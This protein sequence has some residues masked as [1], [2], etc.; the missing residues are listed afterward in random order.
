M[1]GLEGDADTN[2]DKKI[3]AESNGKSETLTGASAPVL[4]FHRLQHTTHRHPLNWFDGTYLVSLWSQFWM[5]N[6]VI[7]GLVVCARGVVRQMMTS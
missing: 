2:Q 3:A 4:H 5:S 6:E 7:L 1:K